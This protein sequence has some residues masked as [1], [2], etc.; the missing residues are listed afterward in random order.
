MEDE[1]EFFRERERRVGVVRDFRGRNRG[2]EVWE[3]M[4]M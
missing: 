2:V 3:S 1:V 4:V